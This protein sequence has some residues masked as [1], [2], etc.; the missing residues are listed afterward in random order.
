MADDLGVDRITVCDW[1]AGRRP[2]PWHFCVK[3]ETST[4]RIAQTRRDASLVVTCEE[5]Q[6]GLDW[7]AVLQLALLRLSAAKMGATA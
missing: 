6:P 4:R 2:V 3:I 5:L 1:A 7:E